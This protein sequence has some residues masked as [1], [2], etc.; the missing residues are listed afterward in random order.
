MAMREAGMD[1][2]RFEMLAE[3]YGADLRRWPAVE[4]DAAALFASAEPEIARAILAEAD[5]LDHLLFAAPS[6]VPSTALR[7]AVLAAAPKAR[8]D[9]RG[10]AFW[11]SG[12]GFAAAAVAGVIVGTSAASL[13]VRDA[14]TEAVL[15]EVLP[16]ETME[17]LPLNLSRAAQPEAA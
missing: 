6:V 11:L 14:R 17:I 4:R 2:A 12:A 13:A 9:P 16:G 7:Q 8:P 5:D 10:L 15:A 3:A 1:R